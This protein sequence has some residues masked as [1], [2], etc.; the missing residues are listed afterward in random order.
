M[1]VFLSAFCN[2]YLFVVI[3][4]LHITFIFI[5]FFS[6]KR[7]LHCDIKP[8]CW[9]AFFPHIFPYTCSPCH[10]HI[11]RIKVHSRQVAGFFPFFSNKHKKLLILNRRRTNPGFCLIYTSIYICIL[12]LWLLYAWGDE[13]INWINLIRFWFCL[14]CNFF[15]H[16]IRYMIQDNYT[17]RVANLH[18][19]YIKHYLQLLCDYDTESWVVEHHNNNDKTEDHDR[20]GW[21]R[22]LLIFSSSF[23]R[24]LLWKVSKRPSCRLWF[25]CESRHAY[26]QVFSPLASCSSSAWIHFIF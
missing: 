17:R 6:Y 9:V 24:C 14:L 8:G 16:M 11:K 3:I 1:D 13:G 4:M 20:F 21:F 26:W 25:W 2:V 23:V 10:C 15:T 5:I 22:K 12:W 19:H 7:E 18:A